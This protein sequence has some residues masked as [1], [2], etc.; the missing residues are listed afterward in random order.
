[1]QRLW[2]S[3]QPTNR[4]QYRY[5]VSG[6]ISQRLQMIAKGVQSVFLDIVQVRGCDFCI[7]PFDSRLQKKT[8]HTPDIVGLIS[9]S[10]C[11]CEIIDVI[12]H[13]HKFVEILYNQAR[14]IHK[15]EDLRY[16]HSADQ[17]SSRY[18]LDATAVE[19]TA[20]PHFEVARPC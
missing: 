15:L 2:P 4:E 7:V 16:T 9:C 17:Y 13:F 8:G 19:Q 20:E 3:F 18:L 1:M 10:H 5:N 12:G 11:I 14:T 6:E